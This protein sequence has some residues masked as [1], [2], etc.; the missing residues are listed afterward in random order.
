MFIWLGIGAIG[1]QVAV[2]LMGERKWVIYLDRVRILYY[3]ENQNVLFYYQRLINGTNSASSF[4]G[5]NNLVL[6]LAW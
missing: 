5:H 3:R 6:K 1:F 4:Y 2:F